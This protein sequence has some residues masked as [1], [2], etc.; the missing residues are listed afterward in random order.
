MP[1]SRMNS[2]FSISLMPYFVRY[3]LSILFNMSQGNLAQS[4]QYFPFRSVQVLIRHKKQAFGMFFSVSLHP[5]HLFLSRRYPLQT[6]Q[7]I[8]Q[9][10]IKFL[11]IIIVSNLALND[12]FF[13]PLQHKRIYRGLTARNYSN[14]L[15][16]ALR[17]RA[18]SACKGGCP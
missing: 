16:L 12:L 18:S 5:W 1:L 8:P 4:K 15:A 7:F 13:R 3:L 14:M 17:G 11:F 2:R 9:G 10:A 6:P